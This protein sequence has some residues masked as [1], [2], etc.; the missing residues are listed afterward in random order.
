MDRTPEGRWV[1]YERATGKRVERWPVDA[2][3]MLERGEYLPDPPDGT[4]AV[5][6]VPLGP[7][8]G[9]EAPPVPTEY[10]PGVPL[11]VTRA[12]EAPASQPLAEPVRTHARKR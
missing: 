7:S 6:D 3:G 10:A 8:A 4:A 12:H 5:D 9:E 1:I 11:V 2:R